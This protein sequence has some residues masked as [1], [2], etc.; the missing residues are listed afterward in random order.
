[1]RLID[2]RFKIN[3]YRILVGLL[4]RFDSYSYSYSLLDDRGGG[5]G[6]GGRVRDLRRK[7]GRQFT[8][9]GRH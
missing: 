4:V 5:R 7:G 8:D 2:L 6:R 1:M 3:S 9:L